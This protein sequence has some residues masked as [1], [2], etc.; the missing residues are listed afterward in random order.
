MTEQNTRRGIWMMVL[1]TL[2]FSAQ[3]GVTRHLTVQYPVQMVVMLRFWFFALFVIWF[4]SR[5]PGG[6]RAAVRTRQAPLHIARGLILV[7]HFGNAATGD[8]G[9]FDLVGAAPD[10]GADLCHLFAADPLCGTAGFSAGQF[11]LDRDRRCCRDVILWPACLDH[12]GADGLGLDVGF[13]LHL[14]CG[15][16]LPDPRL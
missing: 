4:L 10:G 3:D 12:D 6:L 5:Q 7:G 1:T 15:A 9:V 14:L 2:I 8:V 13:V 16:L 11:L